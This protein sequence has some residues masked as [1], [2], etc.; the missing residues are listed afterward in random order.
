MALDCLL[1]RVGLSSLVMVIVVVPVAVAVIIVVVF[2]VTLVLPPSA[3]VWLSALSCCSCLSVLQVLGRILFC[4]LVVKRHKRGK[5][6]L[7]DFVFCLSPMKTGDDLRSRFYPFNG[8]VLLGEAN[9]FNVMPE[10]GSNFYAYHYLY[11]YI[12]MYVCM[13][14]RVSV[15]LCVYIYIHTYVRACV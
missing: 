7:W 2:A 11:M 14:M 10:I 6:G 12:C 13:Y 8:P 4:V 1:I 5:G 9:L 15:G 3:R